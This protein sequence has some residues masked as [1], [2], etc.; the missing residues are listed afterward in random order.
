MA[1]SK[2]HG[3]RSEPR[4]WKKYEEFRR[5]DEMLA[6]YIISKLVNVL[7]PPYKVR[8]KEGQRRGA[9]RRS[10]NEAFDLQCLLGHL[11]PLHLLRAPRQRGA[12]EGARP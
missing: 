10:K 5:L 8:G 9:R 12:Q 3:K 1:L 11:I 7:D 6:L 4:D 2:N